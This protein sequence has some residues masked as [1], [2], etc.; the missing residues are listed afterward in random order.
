M[1]PSTNPQLFRFILTENIVS[2]ELTLIDS[3]GPPNNNGANGNL[4]NMAVFG[5]GGLQAVVE[6][7][8]PPQKT[9]NSM[10]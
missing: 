2:T 9:N 10:C 4:T 5:A 6:S 7:R 1:T 8:V 3:V